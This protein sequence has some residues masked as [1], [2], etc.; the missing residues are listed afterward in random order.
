M[1][2][3]KLY[4][5]VF[6]FG[7]QGCEATTEPTPPLDVDAT[8]TTLVD[9]TPPADTT[10]FDTALP[11]IDVTTN[12]NRDLRNG[13]IA[14]VGHV[15]DGDTLQ[16]W[17]GTSA[18][19]NYIIRMLGLAAPECDKDYRQTPDGSRLVCVADDE[20]YGLESYKFLRD[21]IEGKTV[22]ITCDVAPNEWCETD[23]FDRRLAYIEIDGKDAATEVARAG[24]GFAYTVFS[25]SKRGQICEAEFDARAAKR[26]MWALGTVDQVLAGMSA[27][28]RSW[29]KAHHDRRC[30][31]A[32]D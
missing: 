14:R 8:D 31:E 4:P 16:V 6:V 1:R 30:N 18:P 17:V 5:L 20:L 21:L 27:D 22:R 10:P 24:A 2:V 12:E 3:R 13:V 28:T 32:M 25:A 9:T 23:P 29:Y 7:A 19:K 26:G 15:T 11:N